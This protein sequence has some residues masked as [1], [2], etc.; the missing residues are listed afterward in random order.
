MLFIAAIFQFFDAVQCVSVALLRGLEDT[1]TPFIVSII[2]YWIVGMPIGYYLAFAK[3]WGVTGVWV[4]FLLALATQAI[5]FCL[6][7]FRKV[8][9]I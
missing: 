6:R 4:G 9:Q 8:K 2:A 5:W 3:N 1:T 7:F